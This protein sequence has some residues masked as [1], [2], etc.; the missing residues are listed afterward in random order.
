MTRIRVISSRRSILMVDSSQN[1]VTYLL[2]S[3]SLGKERRVVRF[4]VR[5]QWIETFERKLRGHGY[6]TGVNPLV[7]LY[8]VLRET[9]GA[10]VTGL[11]S[12]GLQNKRGSQWIQ[13]IINVFNYL[14]HQRKK[15]KFVLLSLKQHYGNLK[16]KVKKAKRFTFKE[17]GFCV[18]VKY[19][20]NIIVECLQVPDCE[21]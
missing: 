10:H 6:Q 21:P 11:Y 13:D 14:W 12:T 1:D 18:H 8:Q 7:L 3:L 9:F 16:N 20:Y 19:S 5:Q 17:L 15:K 4:K 2:G